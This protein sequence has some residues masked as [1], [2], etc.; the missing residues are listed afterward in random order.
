MTGTVSNIRSELQDAKT[1]Q[2]NQQNQIDI[3]AGSLANL[4]QEVQKVQKKFF[5]IDLDIK[6]NRNAI[7]KLSA[8]MKTMETSFIDR[9]DGLSAT[10]ETME[11]H[12]NN[13]T[14][15][16][17][18]EMGKIENKLIEQ[19]ESNQKAIQNVDKTSIKARKKISGDINNLR[20]A[21]DELKKSIEVKK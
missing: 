17:S 1:H 5:K 10:M 3:M 9:A 12:L 2:E 14:A 7:N 21:I 13:R 18:T 4:I 11:K 15:E 8:E 20:D 16:L 19:I 6:D